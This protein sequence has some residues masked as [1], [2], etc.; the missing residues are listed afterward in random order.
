MS[1]CACVCVMYAC[2]CEH[3]STHMEVKGQLCVLGSFFSFIWVHG[4][5]ELNSCHWVYMPS[6]LLFESIIHIQKYPGLVIPVLKRLRQK[7]DDFQRILGYL[8]SSRSAGAFMYAYILTHR[9]L[10]TEKHIC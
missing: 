9:H 2:T 8:V 3:Y 1:L 6:T 5:Q 10:H 7:N 4:F